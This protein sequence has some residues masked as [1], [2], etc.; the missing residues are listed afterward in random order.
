MCW[1][2]L[3]Y[4][5]SPLVRAFGAYESEKTSGNRVGSGLDWT[6]DWPRLWTGLDSGLD[7]TGLCTGLWTGLDSGLDWTGL[8]RS[9]LW[10]L[11]W[12]LDWTGLD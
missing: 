6:L 2:G 10:T 8:D 5:A 12:T 1:T 7:W 11:D 9:G 4:F 3:D